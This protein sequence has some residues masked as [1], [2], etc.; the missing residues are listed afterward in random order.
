MGL[1]R[2]IVKWIKKQVKKAGVKGIVIGLSGGVDSALAA[3]LCKEAVGRNLLGVIMPC[4]SD[5][6]DAADAKLLAREFD[7]HKTTVDLEGVYA[8]ILRSYP[9]G[10][11]MAAGM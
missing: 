7:I 8:A 4:Q 5:P 1:K 10:S 11:R 6:E 3:A 2:R 9:P